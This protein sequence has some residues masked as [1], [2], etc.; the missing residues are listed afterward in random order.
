M[1]RLLIFTLVVTLVCTLSLQ[2][3][4]TDYKISSS[5]L[6]NNLTNNVTVS[7]KDGNIIFN[8]CNVNINGYTLNNGNFRLTRPFWV[9]TLKFC[10]NSPDSQIQ[11]LF[12]S[13]TNASINNQT[14]YFY[15]A[16]GQ[17]ILTLVQA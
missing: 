2:K 13:V 5:V 11:N 12:S 17:Q 16:G 7:L 3:H 15:N 6:G 4:Q 8:G 10:F 14:A 1:K 9:T